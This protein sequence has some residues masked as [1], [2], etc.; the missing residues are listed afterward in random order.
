MGRSSSADAR[1]AALLYD[2]DCRVCRFVARTIVRLDRD[3]E[4]AVLPLQD[5]DV[6]PLL[7]PLP[8][9]ERLASWRLARPDGTLVG[10][11][12]GLPE[13]LLA[14]RR[15]RPLGRVIGAV[16]AGMLDA[17]YRLVAR[18]RSRIGPLVPDGP[19]PRTPRKR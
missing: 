1:R 6:T 17:A 8:E 5:P 16:P 10:H 11:G 14:M 13:L 7:A 18:H 9:S 12:A 2:A 3:Q 4:L 19:A 15:T